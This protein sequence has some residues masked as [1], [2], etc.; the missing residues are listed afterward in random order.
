MSDD[1]TLKLSL[2]IEREAEWQR[3]KGLLLAMK[4]NYAW[5]VHIANHQDDETD[6]FNR[7]ITPI[8]KFI[9]E[10]DDANG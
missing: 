8:D 3:I 6:R 5:E 7:F 1:S 9:E 4:I 10:M 2:R